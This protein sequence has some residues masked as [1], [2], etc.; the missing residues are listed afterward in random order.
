MLD[1]TIAPPFKRSNSFDLFTP[2]I[3]TLANGIQVYF[4]SGGNQD[5]IKVELVFP[6]GR[7]IE[8]VSGA[9]YFSSQLISKGT[10]AKTSFEI[11]QTFDRFGAHL[12]VHPGLDFVSISLYSLT[13]YVEPTFRLLIELLTDAT[14]PEKEL[15]QI[16]S[17]YLQNLKVN[18]EK[19][20]FLSSTTFRKNLFGQDHP[21]GKELD[22]KD[23]EKLS[24][25][26]LFDHLKTF[27][28]NITVFV[29]GKVSDSTRRIL[30]DLLADLPH[31]K[32][33]DSPVSFPLPGQTNLRQEKE[34]S[35]QASIRMGRKA[36]LRGH[37]DYVDV[38]FLSHILG[39]YFG[40][41]L[42]KNIR[43]EKGLTY[44]IHASLHALKNDS[45]IVI[46]T[47]VNKENVDLT[48]DEIG[49]ELRRLRED[50]IDQHELE[51]ARN[52]FIGGLQ[53]ELTTSF[54][55]SDKIKTITLFGLNSQY[56]NRMIARIEA[57][58]AEDLIKTGA[59]YFNEEA[60]LQVAI[61]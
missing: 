55:H 1:R 12:E 4:I 27:S 11:A 49:K 39:G 37:T 34:G 43:E 23:V 56:Y 19:T 46:G 59:A 14:L 26:V 52:H 17:I 6:S 28:Q 30:I 58:T 21:Y 7:W 47:D 45:Y 35:V 16:K 48:I 41:R 22:E 9:A 51:I 50:K 8:K 32:T 25:D 15:D 18:N 3:H 40:S 33:S 24:R 54:A 13:Q 20:S 5:V 57:I 2:E 60:F 44:G 36:M 53:A 38:L 29:A 61:G 31:K 10:S 42:M